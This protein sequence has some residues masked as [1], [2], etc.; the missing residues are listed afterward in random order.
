MASTKVCVPS[1]AFAGH[2]LYPYKLSVTRICK[3]SPSAF[4]KL[5]WCKTDPL[6]REG[7]EVLLLVTRTKKMIFWLE[8]CERTT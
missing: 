7:G 4:S 8:L 5:L 6:V 2:F 1:I 3:H